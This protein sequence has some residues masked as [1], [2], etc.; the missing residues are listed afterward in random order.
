MP[1]ILTPFRNTSIFI[2]PNWIYETPL[3]LPLRLLPI[4]PARQMGQHGS[5]ERDGLVEGEATLFDHAWAQSSIMASMLV[6]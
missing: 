2:Q 3:L 5:H 6:S 4:S 1:T